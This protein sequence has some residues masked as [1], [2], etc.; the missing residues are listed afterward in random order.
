VILEASHFV[1]YPVVHT[2]TIPRSQLY[3]AALY[4]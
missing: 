2:A 1:L 3:L 4:R